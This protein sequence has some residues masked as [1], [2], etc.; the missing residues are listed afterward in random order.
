MNAKH[1]FSR[2]LTTHDSKQYYVISAEIAKS[3][4]V[5]TLQYWIS[6]LSFNQM[7]YNLEI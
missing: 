1:N 6:I 5:L 3:K 7:N 2:F 4:F